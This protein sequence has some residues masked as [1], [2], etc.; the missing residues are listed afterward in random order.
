M[1][2]K[3]VCRIRDWITHHTEKPLLIAC[4]IFLAT[5]ENNSLIK[6]LLGEKHHFFYFFPF[7]LN[8]FVDCQHLKKTVSR[9][10]I[11]FGL[12]M[13]RDKSRKKKASRDEINSHSFGLISDHKKL[14]SCKIG[15]PRIWSHQTRAKRSGPQPTSVIPKQQY[16]K[17]VHLARLMR[18]QIGS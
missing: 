1:D 11:L 3:N 17:S 7:T 6:Q 13:I 10:H 9:V 8:C 15:Y 14:K 2:Q 18:P 12:H 5:G 4:F 16:Q